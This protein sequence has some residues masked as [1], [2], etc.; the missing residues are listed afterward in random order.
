MCC[1]LDGLKT[2]TLMQ[3]RAMLAVI[4]FNF[5]TAAVSNVST[6]SS[7]M[8]KSYWAGVKNLQNQASGVKRLRKVAS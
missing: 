3:S 8:T 2:Y 4:L 7:V 1:P 5:L 6:T